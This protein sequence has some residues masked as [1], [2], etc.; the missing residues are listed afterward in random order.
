MEKDKRNTLTLKNPIM[1]NG[2]EGSRRHEKHDD[3]GRR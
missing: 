1:I 2:Q 3:H